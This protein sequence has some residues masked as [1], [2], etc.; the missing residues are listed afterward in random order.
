MA[1]RAR[2]RSPR[3]WHAR[4]PGTICRTLRSRLLHHQVLPF[5]P[6][7]SLLR[8]GS[9]SRPIPETRRALL[10]SH[11][12]CR[13]MSRRSVTSWR[14][15]VLGVGGGKVGQPWNVLLFFLLLLLL[16]DLLL[17][18]VVLLVVLATAA[19]AAS[20]SFQ[21]GEETCPR[22]A[23]LGK[24]TNLEAKSWTQMKL[25]FLLFPVPFPLRSIFH[26]SFS[27]PLLLR[28]QRR[29]QC[30]GRRLRYP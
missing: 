22:P 27:H 14:K 9:G 28:V 25:Q 16:L 3:S 23:A 26:F 13:K 24:E 6:S 15:M 17:L 18:L 21:P 1:S 2:R 8:A 29:R 20:A 10:C 5:L 30:R 11:R 7:S 19:A 4:R 12:R